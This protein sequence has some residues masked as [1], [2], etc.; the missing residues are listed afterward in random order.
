MLDEP[1][2]IPMEMAAPMSDP[3]L[4]T[5]GVIPETQMSIKALRE[6]RNLGIVEL[7][8]MAGILPDHLR[9]IEAGVVPTVPERQAI[10]AALNVPVEQIADV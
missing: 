5:P 3:T 10:A 9:A 1:T 7:A 6:E 8:G 4:A 2:A